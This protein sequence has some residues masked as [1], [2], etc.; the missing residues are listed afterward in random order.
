MNAM[1]VAPT[2]DLWPPPRAAQDDGFVALDACHIRL[3][4]AAGALEELVATVDRDGDT[5]AVRV[6]AAAIA[7]FY[8]TTA[9]QHHEDEERHVFPALLAGTDADL[10]QA[11]LQLQQDHGWLAEDWMELEPH[12]QA[13]AAGCGSYDIGTLRQGIEILAALQRDHIALEES[14]VYPEARAR[15][16]RA[17]RREMGRE[18]A[19]RRR[20]ERSATGR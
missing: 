9:R 12:V 4:A 18:M 1:P 2:G 15:L 6:S 8:A 13:I 7:D 19:A 3:L 5:P 10:V 16:G 20:A 11:V 17:G 14:L